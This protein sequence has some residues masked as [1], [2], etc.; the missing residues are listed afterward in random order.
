MRFPSPLSIGPSSTA[1]ALARFITLLGGRQAIQDCP[2]HPCGS[3]AAAPASCPPYLRVVLAPQIKAGA[4]IPAHPES[5]SFMLKAQ[6]PSADPLQNKVHDFSQKASLYLSSYLWGLSI[7]V[8][9]RLCGQGRSQLEAVLSKR[10]RSRAAEVR[11]QRRFLQSTGALSKAGC[12]D[13]CSPVQDPCPRAMRQAPIVGNAAQRR[14]SD[15]AISG[16]SGAPKS[17]ASGREARL[18]TH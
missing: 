3:F 2:S 4:I 11:S 7:P 14:A 9:M 15:R 17:H 18:L 6:C 1:L 5:S 10:G 13:S 8:P 16:V 12:R